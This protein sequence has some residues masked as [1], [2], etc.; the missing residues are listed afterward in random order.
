MLSRNWRWMTQLYEIKAKTAENFLLTAD[1][2]IHFEHWK[3]LSV[4]VV[5]R[6]HQPCSWCYNLQ[7]QLWTNLF[8]EPQTLSDTPVLFAQ[9]WLVSVV[10]CTSKFHTSINIW[11]NTSFCLGISVCKTGSGIFLT[12]TKPAF[13]PFH[14]VTVRWTCSPAQGPQCSCTCLHSW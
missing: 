9:M 11:K 1:Q 13:V 8:C 2:L 14:Y 12:L 4:Q 6:Y 3:K 5:A 7:T 10:T